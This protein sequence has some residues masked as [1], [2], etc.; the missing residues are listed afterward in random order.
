MIT[1]KFIINII[2]MIIIIIIMIVRFDCAFDETASNEMVYKYTARWN[3]K[4]VIIIIVINNNM[5]FITI[6]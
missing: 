1:I 2:K 4:I 3:I 6:V 5:L